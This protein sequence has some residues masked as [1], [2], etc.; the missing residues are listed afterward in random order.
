MD[1]TVSDDEGE[2][3]GASASVTRAEVAA[4]GGG[5]LLAAA[6]DVLCF[7]FRSKFL[8]PPRNKQKQS[9]CPPPGASRLTGTNF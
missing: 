8:K 2:C 5:E 4:D 9:G 7:G 6:S 1:P 3:P